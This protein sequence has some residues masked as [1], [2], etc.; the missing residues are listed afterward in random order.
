M[1][2]AYGKSFPKSEPRSIHDLLK[3]LREERGFSVP[4][5]ARLTG[6]SSTYVY[7]LENGSRKPSPAAVLRLARVL[8]VPTRT[9]REACG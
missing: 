4:E 5:L 8:R 3:L 6:Y 1:A 7:K 9:F 2:V